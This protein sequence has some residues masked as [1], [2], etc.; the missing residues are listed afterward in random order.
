MYYREVGREVN[1]TGLVVYKCY[2]VSVATLVQVNA[3]ALSPP[4][5]V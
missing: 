2:Q 3:L 1:R 5:L 4:P